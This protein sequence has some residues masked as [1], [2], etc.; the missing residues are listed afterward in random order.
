[1]G[2]THG[3]WVVGSKR[4]Q[5]AP[6]AQLGGSADTALRG[7]RAPLALSP[8]S[9]FHPGLQLR[10]ENSALHPPRRSHPGLPGH[11]ALQGPSK[12]PAPG[13]RTP[14]RSQRTSALPSHLPCDRGPP[15]PLQASS[16]A[17]FPEATTPRCPGVGARSPGT[18]LSQ[19]RARAMHPNCPPCPR[20]DRTSPS[21]QAP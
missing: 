8:A 1:M 11:L 7:H 15:S 2:P 5:L 3:I 21:D 19:L 6:S 14:M 9:L 18:T 16:Q 4:V 13:P 20:G 17:A 10:G 12:N